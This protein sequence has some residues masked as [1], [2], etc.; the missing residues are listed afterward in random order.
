[1]KTWS[2]Y[3]SDDNRCIVEVDWYVTICTVYI[4][5]R[6]SH[7]EYEQEILEIFRE[8]STKI[9][10][11]HNPKHCMFC[12]KFLIV[13]CWSPCLAP[14]IHCFFCCHCTQ[15]FMAW[16]C[17]CHLFW[18]VE[19]TPWRGCRRLKQYFWRFSHLLAQIVP[20]STTTKIA[21]L[22]KNQLL[23]TSWIT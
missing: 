22:I 21:Y 3:K 18:R 7:F 19:T 1:M 8:N 2:K 12:A 4:L 10:I 23:I 17:Y 14:T 16:L 5:A 9:S 15:P 13:K 20:A 11:N 6:A